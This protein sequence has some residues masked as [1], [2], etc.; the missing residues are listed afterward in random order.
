MQVAIGLFQVFCAAIAFIAFLAATIMALG[1]AVEH[2][3]RVW[4]SDFTP[5][6]GVPTLGESAVGVLRGS[7]VFFF[8][9]WMSGDI[10]GI[11]LT[12]CQNIWSGSDSPFHQLHPGFRLGFLEI[13]LAS[14]T[15]SVVGGLMFVLRLPPSFDRD[16]FKLS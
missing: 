10:P 6:H 3:K 5:Y 1:G 16:R 12:I 13:A 7:I 4:N 14:L 15:P 11:A 9:F 8:S 2:R